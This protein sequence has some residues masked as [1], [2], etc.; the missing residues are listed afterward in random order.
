MGWAGIKLKSQTFGKSNAT[1]F[2]KK[3]ALDISLHQHKFIGK[4]QDIWFRALCETRW[5]ISKKFFKD[6][7]IVLFA[8]C[9]DPAM[10][11]NATKALENSG[12]ELIAFK[13]RKH[14][15]MR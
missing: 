11:A 1:E 3:L 8:V 14:F 5:N 9:V 10:I 7:L 2:S 4:K 15:S 6:Y 12:S 13:S